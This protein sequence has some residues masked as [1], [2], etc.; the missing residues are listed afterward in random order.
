MRWE[1]F[2]FCEGQ[3]WIDRLW[4]VVLLAVILAVVFAD[5]ALWRPG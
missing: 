3:G 1:P 4:R 2:E 5:M